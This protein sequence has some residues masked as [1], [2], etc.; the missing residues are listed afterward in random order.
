MLETNIGEIGYP[1]LVRCGQ[2][3]S[4]G[5][6]QKHLQRVMR[7]RSAD[8]LSRS[9]R[10]Q[11]VFLHDAQYTLAIR[12]HPAMTKFCSDAAVSIAPMVLDSYFLYRCPDR[13]V[14][15]AR[16]LFPKPAI[17]SSPADLCQRAHSFHAELCL[18][19]MASLL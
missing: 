6:V 4:L 8:E 18:A 17:E 14:F 10:Q 16:L 1:E 11:I 19:S 2:L 12:Y 15:R 7:I 3:H 5:K 9:Y 13:H